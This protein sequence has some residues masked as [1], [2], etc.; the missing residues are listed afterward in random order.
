MAVK[1]GE[2]RRDNQ[3]FKCAETGGV[4]AQRLVKIFTEDNSVKYSTD[5]C[6]G[7]LGVTNTVAD[8]DKNVSVCTDGDVYVKAGGAIAIGDYLYAAPAGDGTVVAIPI[9]VTPSAN[10]YCVGMALMDAASGS[11]TLMRICQIPFP[12]AS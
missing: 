8:H 1:V 6:R 10:F 4:L 5:N 3:T 12:M 7:T 2:R 11:I 9:G